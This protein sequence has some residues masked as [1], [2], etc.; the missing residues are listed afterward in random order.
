MD[1]NLQSVRRINSEELHS[2]KKEVVASSPHESGV[3]KWNDTSVYSLH[4][5]TSHS[6]AATSVT[7][8]SPSVSH[9]RPASWRSQDAR[10]SS[11]SIPPSLERAESLAK[12]LMVRGSKLFKRQH[13]KT[14]PPSLRTLYWVVD[15]QNGMDKPGRQR[16]SL[17]RDS[18]HNRMH[19][20]GSKLSSNI[21]LL[22]CS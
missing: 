13:S 1:P 17:H 15:T 3:K 11:S 9:E 22:G 20:T 8:L 16:G 4:G 18:Q 14:S 19:S 12:T 10:S 2:A 5:S 7:N 21:S 6:A